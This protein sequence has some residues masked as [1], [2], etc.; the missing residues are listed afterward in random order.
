MI[1]YDIFIIIKH[2]NVIFTFLLFFIIY[3]CNTVILIILKIF[4]LNFAVE[5]I[6]LYFMTTSNYFQYKIT[7]LQIIKLLISI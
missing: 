6:L 7:I 4:Y 2:S 3:T 1:N 5:K